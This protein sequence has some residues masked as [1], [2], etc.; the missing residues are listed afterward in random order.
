MQSHF[1]IYIIIFFF[2]KK[3]QYST[4]NPSHLKKKEPTSSQRYFLVKLKLNHYQSLFFFK[5]HI[6]K[7]FIEYKSFFSRLS[8]YFK[9]QLQIHKKKRNSK[10]WVKKEKGASVCSFRKIINSGVCSFNQL[11]RLAATQR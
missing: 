8:I 6:P 2:I 1:L 9:R 10:I 7:L 4:K 11:E 3:W 5:I